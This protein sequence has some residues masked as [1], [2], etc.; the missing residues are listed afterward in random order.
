MDEAEVCGIDN[1]TSTH[2]TNNGDGT[3]SCENGHVRS[4]IGRGADI[5]DAEFGADRGV[6]TRKRTEK[7]TKESLGA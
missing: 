3:Y 4:G 1:C 7:I 2:W 5:G 6:T